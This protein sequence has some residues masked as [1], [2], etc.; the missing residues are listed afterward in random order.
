MYLKLI[1]EIEGVLDVITQILNHLA[2][3]LEDGILE[4]GSEADTEEVQFFKGLRIK[5]NLVDCIGYNVWT[6]TPE[7]EEPAPAPAPQLEE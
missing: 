7:A 3:L 1:S 2:R 4:L 5:C 6:F